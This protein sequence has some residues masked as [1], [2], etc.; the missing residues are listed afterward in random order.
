[1]TTSA[2]SNVMRALGLVTGIAFGALL[3]R[4]GLGR[5]GAISKQIRF[6]D[7]RVVKTMATAVVVGGLGIHALAKMGLVKK[8][9]KPLKLGGIIGGAALFGAGMAVLGYCPGTSLA[10][11]GEGRRDAL[12]GAIG[13]LAGAG[14]FVVIYPKLRP[15]I[16]AGGDFGKVTLPEF[17]GT[18]FPKSV[19]RIANVAGLS[20]TLLSAEPN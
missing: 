17:L 12:I 18:S 13:M 5:P 15:L 4:G 10:A 14:T 20:S 7:W 8:E 9:I 11:V 1:M 19:P 16:E 6:Q 3:Q 2:D